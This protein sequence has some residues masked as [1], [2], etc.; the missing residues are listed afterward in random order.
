MKPQGPFT[1]KD[2][3]PYG[4]HVIDAKGNWVAKVD[5]VAFGRRIAAALNR[6]EART[7]PTKRWEAEEYAGAFVRLKFDGEEAHSY[8]DVAALLNRLGATLSK[9]RATKGAKR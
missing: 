6:D 2:S 8:H 5:T 9:R 7:K 1:A 4:I 3:E